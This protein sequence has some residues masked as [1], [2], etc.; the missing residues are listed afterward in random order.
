[1]TFY[2]DLTTGWFQGNNSQVKD[3]RYF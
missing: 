2:L 3:N 1:M